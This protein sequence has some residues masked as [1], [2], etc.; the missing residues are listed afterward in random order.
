MG[1]WVR[2]NESVLEWMGEGVRVG[3]KKCVKEYE[4]V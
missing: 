1:G 2:G 4:G 3:E